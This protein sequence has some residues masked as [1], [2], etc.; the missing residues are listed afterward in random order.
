MNPVSRLGLLVNF[1]R[2]HAHEGLAILLAA[3]RDAGIMLFAPP[4]TAAMSS[5]VQPCF[6][7]D[8]VKQ[9]VQG[10]ISLGGDGSFLAASHLLAG[11]SL[12][13]IGF[14][15]GHLGYL[16]AVNEEGSAKFGDR[17]LY[18]GGAHHNYGNGSESKWG[19]FC[20]SGR[21]E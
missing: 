19:M 20:V 17:S 8:F 7:E 5:G 14:N 15:I 12:P 6:P 13:L 3:A 16:T 4:E 11:T 21:L 18:S 10:V 1:T 2:P 9:G